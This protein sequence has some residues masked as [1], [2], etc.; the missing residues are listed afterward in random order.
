MLAADSA[1]HEEILLAAY[2]GWGGAGVR[3]WSRELGY[4][5]AA[6]VLTELARAGRVVVD[7]SGV[8]YARDA[9]KAPDPVSDA[10][11][12]RLLLTRRAHRAH[13][14]LDRRGDTVLDLTLSRLLHTGALSERR[15]RRWGVLPTTDRAPSDPARAARAR[16]AIRRAATG[17]PTE[18]TAT[19]AALLSAA[20]LST[21]LALPRTNWPDCPPP[22]P[23]VASELALTLAISRIP[24]ALT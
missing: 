10:L 3:G 22:I 16:E 14:W 7:A 19:A 21:H 17:T 9:T 8:V 4:V 18:R 6:A 5:L 11:L 24:P 23:T 15:V 2:D 20:N 1:L 13:W 12:E